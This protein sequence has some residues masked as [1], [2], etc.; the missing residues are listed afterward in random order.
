MNNASQCLSNSTFGVV[1]VV[2]LSAPQ[3]ADGSSFGSKTKTIGM[4][5]QEAVFALECSPSKVMVM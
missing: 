4:G 1:V 5:S 2:V 3:A